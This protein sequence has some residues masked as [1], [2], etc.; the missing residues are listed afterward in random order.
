[1]LKKI[2]QSPFGTFNRKE[3]TSAE[4]DIL[5]GGIIKHISVFRWIMS[6][7]PGIVAFAY[8]VEDVFTL[9]TAVS[10]IAVLLGSAWYTIS[11]QNVSEA[12]LEA[13]V[14]D[15]I[16]LSMFRAFMLCVSALII[17]IIAYFGRA[18]VPELFNY[19]L[20]DMPFAM[21]LMIFVLNSSWILLVMT[22]IWKAS[23]AY[24]AADSLL[25]D[26]FPTLMRGAKANAENHDTSKQI[27][28]LT[29]AVEELVGQLK[30]KY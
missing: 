13:G 15:Y 20:D 11:F 12:Q 10:F 2:I 21:R 18:I 19:T 14:A 22:D 8:L 5:D 28:L 17:C 23:V 1:M 26:G 27:A 29:A 16:T 3:L 9:L 24:D 7:I 6:F 30:N 4:C 25:G